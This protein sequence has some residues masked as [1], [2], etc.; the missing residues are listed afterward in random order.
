MQIEHFAELRHEMESFQTKLTAALE[1][2]KL[3]LL[4]A[5]EG[6][7]QDVQQ[8]E[9]RQQE[10]NNRLKQLKSQERALEQEIEI[11]ER[12]RD[13]TIAKAEVYKA[14]KQQ[15]DSERAVLTRDSQELRKLLLQKQ[16]E[17][18]NKRI[19]L[20]KQQQKDSL[21]AKAYEE[22]LG[23]RIEA[24]EPE[25]LK[26][27]FNRVSEFEE[28]ASCEIAIDLSQASYKIIHSAPRLEAGAVT[29]LELKLSSD[30]DLG[31]FLKESRAQ[32]ITEY[33]RQ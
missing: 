6:Y 23:L 28:N 22:L 7:L 24:P 13:E 27:I 32:L 15:I 16:D 8:L 1:E 2:R 11:S 26:F 18:Q 33:S 31:S 10:S 25:I 29:D 17:I 19:I 3:T 5:V 20:Q 14:R 21:D 4:R 30:G 9:A 12:E